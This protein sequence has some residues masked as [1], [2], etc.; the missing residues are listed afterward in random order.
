MIA[1]KSLGLISMSF[2][3]G[4]LAQQQ[5][6]AVIF[7]SLA[8]MSVAVLVIVMLY[9]HRPR[10]EVGGTALVKDWKD[11]LQRFYLYFALFGVAYSI[12]SF[13]TDGLVTLHFSD[14][15]GADVFSIGVYGMSR[16]CG[17]LLGPGCMSWCRG[18]W[19]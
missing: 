2:A 17:A 4:A 18:G 14:A 5:G 1:G 13:G 7:R 6:Y 9:P 3:F 15:R 10:K 16:G 12:A 8:A 19:V 11:L